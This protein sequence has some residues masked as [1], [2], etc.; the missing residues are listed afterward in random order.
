MKKTIESMSSGVMNLFFSIR[1]VSS[2]PHFG[3]NVF[4]LSAEELTI[5]SISVRAFS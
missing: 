4:V 5:G 3:Q 2:L 1:T